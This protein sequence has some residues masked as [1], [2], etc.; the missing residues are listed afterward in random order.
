VASLT[1]LLLPAQL[2]C[3]PLSSVDCVSALWNETVAVLYVLSALTNECLDF[4]KN[5]LACFLCFF[6]VILRFYFL[7]FISSSNEMALYFRNVFRCL[8]WF[9]G[10]IATVL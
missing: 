6:G 4:I 1:F 3:L 2:S 10:P 5:K 9:I 7:Y 8:Y